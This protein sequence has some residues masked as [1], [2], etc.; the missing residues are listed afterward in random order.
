[1]PR[2][3]TK[4]IRV[5]SQCPNY[6]SYAADAFYCKIHTLHYRD[7]ESNFDYHLIPDIHGEIPGWCGL[8]E[9]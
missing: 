7:I 1:M 5:C 6:Q 9:E 2:L 3:Y 4:I 8:E